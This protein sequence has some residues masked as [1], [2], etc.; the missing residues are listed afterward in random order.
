MSNDCRIPSY[1]KGYLKDADFADD[2]LEAT[3]VSSTVN[4]NL[5]IYCYREGVDDD[6]YILDRS[7]YPS[8]MLIIA[9]D[10]ETRE[11]FVVFDAEKHG[12]DAMLCNE[13]TEF[14]KRELKKYDKSGNINISI[15]Y[16][17]NFDEEID[18]LDFD[19][20]GKVLLIDG[21]HVDLE[22]FKGEAFDSISLSFSD[23]EEC[24][25]DFECA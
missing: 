15:I 13:Q 20:D 17:I 10:P 9:R 14:G 7:D 3:L 1:L 12:Y 11:E 16:S 4:S 25:F 18:E 19:D 6:G 8:R 21:R 2:I 23:T 22:T 24:F 5:E